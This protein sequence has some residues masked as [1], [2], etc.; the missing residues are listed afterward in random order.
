MRKSDVKIGADVW[1]R[2][3]GGA[4]GKYLG[5]VTSVGPVLVN[6]RGPD[7]IAG[8]ATPAEVTQ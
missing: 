4:R 2:L 7:G 1:H 6:Y 3:P 8:I 5:T